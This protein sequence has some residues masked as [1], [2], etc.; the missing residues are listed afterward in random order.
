MRL[1]WFT[2]WPPEPTGVA[3]RSFEV[4]QV[5]A[6]RG[7]AID[8]FVD[9]TAVSVEERWPDREPVAGEIR[10]Q[11]AH[12]F[13]WRH[14]RQQYDLVVYQL[15]NSV[16][17]GFLWPYLLRYPGL[18]ILHDSHLHHSRGATLI[19]PASADAYRAAFAADHPDVNPDVAELAVAGFDG[20]YHYYWPMTASAIRRSRAVG[21]HVRSVVGSLRDAHPDVPIEYVALGEGRQHVAGDDERNR[22]RQRLGIPPGRTLFG[23][24]GGLTIDKRVPLVLDAFVRLR[25]LTPHVHLLLG[26]R[27]DPAL[28]LDDRIDATVGDAVT[29]ATDLDDD[30]FEDAVAAVDVS[31]NL[32]WPTARETSGPWLRAL[33][34]ARA[35]VTLDLVH[36]AHLPALDPQTWMARPGGAT[37]PPITVAI[38]ILDEAHSLGL[39]M[40][41]LAADADLRA[42]LGQAARAWWT[43]EHTLTR[44]ADDYERIMQTARHS[45]TGTAPLPEELRPDPLTHTR[46]LVG[47]F[48]ELTCTLF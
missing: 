25:R 13:I 34:A 7:H 30:A 37:H 18:T 42:R 12:D 47:P 33:A 23:L 24:F 1:A 31:L 4:T 6:S 38:D 41:R 28:G 27:P 44:M 39:A 3:G 5:L 19:T 21:V 2:P 46:A 35:T 15:G 40:A 14:H 32:R 8:V 22:T 45:T 11:S 48:G 26:G 17:H 43:R 9:R 10:P 16:A 20:A 29:L 36:Q